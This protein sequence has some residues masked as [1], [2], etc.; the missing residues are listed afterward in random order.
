MTRILLAV[1]GSDHDVSSTRWLGRLF[2]GAAGST[3]VTVLTVAHLRL[4]V[5]PPLRPGFVPH[6]PSQEEMR[7]MEAQTRTEADALVTAVQTDLEAYG[8]SVTTRVEWGPTADVI[9]KVAETGEHDLI[10][11][12]QRGAG[13]VADLIIGSVSDRVIRR[14][15]IP[16]IVMPATAE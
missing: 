4:P 5:P 3:E 6:I 9:V 16:V 14:A 11:I 8:F 2:G 1:D 7:D 15:R 13:R 10:A 12:G